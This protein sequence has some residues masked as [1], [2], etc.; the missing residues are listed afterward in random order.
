[1]AASQRQRCR[2]SKSRMRTFYP[3]VDGR[4]KE[5]LTKGYRGVTIGADRGKG[6]LGS[7][8]PLTIRPLRRIA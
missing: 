5:R 4:V 3:W 1:M 7:H 6:N 8:W 2:F